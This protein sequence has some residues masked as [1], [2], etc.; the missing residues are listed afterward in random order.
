MSRAGGWEGEE[1][2]EEG[3][4]AGRNTAYCAPYHFRAL[5]DLSFYRIIFLGP[6][7]LPKFAIRPSIA[8]MGFSASEFEYDWKLYE[9]GSI[10]Q[11]DKRPNPRQLK[12][13]LRGT[14]W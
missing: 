3:A 8:S 10:A 11:S 7:E 1:E 13:S 2:V 5:M 12:A 6:Y 14:S 9:K 4:G